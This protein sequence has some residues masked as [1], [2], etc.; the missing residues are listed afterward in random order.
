MNLPNALLPGPP[1][2]DPSELNQQKS[3]PFMSHM[4]GGA[5][6]G[7]SFLKE[8][9]TPNTAEGQASYR[10]TPNCGSAASSSSSPVAAHRPG[11][12]ATMTPLAHPRSHNGATE[13]RTTH[14]DGNEKGKTVAAQRASTAGRSRGDAISRAIFS[15]K[16]VVNYKRKGVGRDAGRVSMGS[17]STQ[18]RSKQSNENNSNSSSTHATRRTKRHHLS[19]NGSKGS[20]H[21]SASEEELPSLSREG[22]YNNTLHS[23][24]N[25]TS[26]FN[27]LSFS[28]SS[29]LFGRP[30]GKA[31]DDAIAR[32]MSTR[33]NSG[34]AHGSSVAE[35]A[36]ASTTPSKR[37][38][39]HRYNEG[40]ASAGAEG[41]TAAEKHHHRHHHQHQPRRS[42]S[43]EG[44]GSLRLHRSQRSAPVVA[45]QD[46]P[47][48]ENASGNT[49]TATAGERDGGGS[50]KK[51]A[52]ALLPPHTATE[53]SGSHVGGSSTRGSLL[54][55]SFADSGSS[56]F[57]GA[58]S[59]R[60][61]SSS[62]TTTGGSTANGGGGHRLVSR[63]SVKALK[64]KAARARDASNSSS[65]FDSELR[66]SG[67]GGGGGGAAPATTTEGGTAG[68]LHPPQSGGGHLSEGGFRRQ[69]LTS[70]SAAQMSG[71]NEMNLP[72]FAPHSPHDNQS[73][74][75]ANDNYLQMDPR[76]DAADATQ[77]TLPP[78]DNQM[79]MACVALSSDAAHLLNHHHH[80]PS[81]AATSTNTM[82]TSRPKALCVSRRGGEGGLSGVKHQQGSPTGDQAERST[83]GRENS[84]QIKDGRENS[85]SPNG[86]SCSR[87]REKMILTELYL[88]GRTNVND[89]KSSRTSSISSATDQA[90]TAPPSSGS[91]V[92]GGSSFRDP[93]AQRRRRPA[94]Q[95]FTPW[96]VD[97]KLF[98][99]LS[100]QQHS[101]V[102]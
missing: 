78:M 47:G 44:N 60:N 59:S 46:A 8:S 42:S 48:A 1:Q 56:S 3:E 13:F 52:A 70:G 18:Q 28:S 23:R 39:H 54:T 30:R 41:E 85:I 57:S 88:A 82:P 14:S 76:V 32:K 31:V 90:E 26:I 89:Y 84:S 53:L 10:R 99:Q 36:S 65:S 9:P 92:V 49:A 80:H 55:V 67:S 101:D 63:E 94:T 4:A 17:G 22:S 40:K 43:L 15:S 73:G 37:E 45:V 64:K 27:L 83:P 69:R 79:I 20:M 62:N 100:S 61:S 74:G 51:A 87:Q 93:S 7:L 35:R 66:V 6:L 77:G 95:S 11:G 19:R 58:P 97:V 81:L 98:Q 34:G 50:A 72:T 38:K 68:R 2:S 102:S 96:T 5:L 12:I 16:E 75:G 91:S 29:F 25:S 86:T 24:L 71:G 21:M 33:K